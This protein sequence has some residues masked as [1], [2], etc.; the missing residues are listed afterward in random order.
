MPKNV[1][2]SMQFTLTAVAG[3][4]LKVIFEAGFSINSVKS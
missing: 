4:T 1:V 3:S 2:Y